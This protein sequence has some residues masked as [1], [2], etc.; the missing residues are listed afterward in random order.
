L[1]SA[2]EIRGRLA[3]IVESSDDAIVSKTL[4]GIITSWNR[5][6]ENIFGYTAQEAVGK[7]ISLIIPKDRRS[8]EDEVISCIR[9]GQKIDH[10][11][12]VR[13]TKDG[14]LIDISLTVSPVKDASGRV[15]GASKVARD[16]T[17]R[18]RGEAEREALLLSEREARAEAERAGRMKEEF[19]ATLSHELRTPLNAIVGWTYILK[20]RP[21]SQET[22]DQGLS[23]IDRNV[24]LQVQLVSDLLDMSR[25]VSGKMRLDVQRVELPLIVAAALESL[26]PAAAAK[27]IRVS[28]IVEPITEPVYGDS[29]RLQQVVWNLLSNA[30]KFTPR[31][32]RI[33]LVLCRASSHVDLSV[34]DDGKGMKAEFLPHVFERF[35]QADSSATREHG[36]LGLGLSIVRQLVELHGGSV[37]AAS[38]GEGRGSTFTVSLPLGAM[39]AAPA[40]PGAI[41]P[42]APVWPLREV[43]TVSLAGLRVLVVD[44]E[45][46]A[47]EVIRRVLEE[48]QAEVILAANADEALEALA[49]QRADVIVSDIGMPGQDGYAMM[50][51]ARRKGVRVP[52]AALTAFARSED[53]TRALQAGYQTHL[54]K[55]VEPPELVAAVA[56]LAHKM[57]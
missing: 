9:K 56:A 7:H 23:V 6:A 44:D 40:E 5:S 19:L 55:P 3:A 36:G 52:A 45:S 11:E 26:G 17:D 27:A 10:F 34:S 25:I 54:A 29:A 48:R 33:Q 31:G 30:V 39:Q 49:N 1:N 20:T 4:D 46:D 53:R 47:R 13:Q 57:P 32:G 51:E 28:S 24:R 37:R 14:R 12:T 22:L 2:E 21:L 50:R 8:E 38:A 43:D 15:I 41:H 18:K 42:R 35:R 16:I